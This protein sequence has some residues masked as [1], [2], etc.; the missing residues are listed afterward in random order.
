MLNNNIKGDF[1]E[2]RWE[3]RELYNNTNNIPPPPPHTHTHKQTSDRG[4]GTAVKILIEQVRPEK[5]RERKERII[6][7]LCP[8]NFLDHSGAKRKREKHSERERVVGGGG[9]GGDGR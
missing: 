8:V 1:L 4:I 5:D 3:R 7:F 9:G 6:R 2:R